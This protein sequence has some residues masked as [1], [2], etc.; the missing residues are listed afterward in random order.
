MLSHCKN[1]LTLVNRRTDGRVD[2]TA[3]IGNVNKLAGF[4]TGGWKAVIHDASSYTYCGDMS[5]YIVKMHT[6]WAG[7][8]FAATNSQATE[9]TQSHFLR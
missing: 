8:Q 7:L 6:R 2:I 5:Q 3:D 9:T 1:K 4:K